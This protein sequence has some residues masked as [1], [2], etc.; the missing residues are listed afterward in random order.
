MTC[1]SIQPRE[2]IFA[3]DYGFLSFAKKIS[4]NIDK[5]TS[6]NLS[7]KYSWKL[8][9]HAKQSATDALKRVI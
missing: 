3:K 9:D 6:K 1:Y 7:D 4:E 2:T 5:N 8:I